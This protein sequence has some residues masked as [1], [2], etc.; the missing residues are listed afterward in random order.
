MEEGRRRDG[1]TWRKGQGKGMG[2]AEGRERKHARRWRLR[3]METEHQM[4]CFQCRIK[5]G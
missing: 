4:R 1:G 3:K 5:E 2:E